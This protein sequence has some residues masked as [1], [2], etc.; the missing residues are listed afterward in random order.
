M[1]YTSFLT[2]PGPG[3]F[4]HPSPGAGNASELG[5]ISVSSS[6]P[7]CFRYSWA[8]DPEVLRQGLLLPSSS[9]GCCKTPKEPKGSSVGQVPAMLLD[10]KVIFYGRKAPK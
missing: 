6:K 2:E 3:V 7:L 5:N 4:V 8:G 9:Q 1:S 10:P